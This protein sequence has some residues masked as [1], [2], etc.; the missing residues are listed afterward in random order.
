MFRNQ[1]SRNGPQRSGRRADQ[2]PSRRQPRPSN[3]P[4]RKRHTQPQNRSL[5]DQVQALTSAVRRLVVTREPAPAPQ[6]KPRP[7]NRPANPAKRTQAPKPSQPRAGVLKSKPGKRERTA[8]RLQADRVFPIVD[9]SKRTVGYAVALE[10]K[11]MKPLHVKG[12]IDHPTLASLKFTKST[13]FDMEYAPLPTSMRSDAFAYTSKHPDGFYSWVHG[14]VQ[15]TN[16]RFSIPTGAGGPGDSGRPIL[17]NTGKVVA[18]VLGGANEGSRT[19]LSVVT[20]NQS[21]TA[22]RTVPDD[23]VEWSAVVTAMC[24][25]GNI[26]FPCTAPPF[27]FTDS[28]DTTLDV[29]EAHVDHPNYFDM[30]YHMLGCQVSARRAKRQTSLTQNEYRLAAPYAGRCPACATGSECFSPVKIERVWG[31]PETSSLRIQF[32]AIAGINAKGTPDPALVTYAS[33]SDHRPISANLSEITVSTGSKCVVT[34][35]YGYFILANCP[36]GDI[37]TVSLKEHM[38]TIE[39][40]H[41]KPDVGYEEFAATPIHGTSMRCM[42]FNTSRLTSATH[43]T[44]HRTKPQSETSLISAVNSTVTITVPTNSTVDYECNCAGAFLSGFLRTT[45]KIQGCT[46]ANQCIAALTAR[47]RWTPN[48]D[49]FIRHTDHSPRGKTHVPYPIEQSLCTVPLAR[50][51]AARYSHDSV[52]LTLVTNR[53]VLLTSR[54]LGLE[55]NATAEWINSSTRRTFKLPSEGLEYTWGNNEPIRLWPQGS[56]SGDAHGYPHEAIAYHYSRAPVHTIA[57]LSVLAFVIIASAIFCACK[58]RSL[59]SALRSPY[60]LAPNATVP[61]CLTLL[62]CVRQAKAATYFEAS[63]YLWDNY[64]PMF[65]AQLAIPMASIFLLLKCCSLT[66]TFLAVAGALL[67][68]ISA[69]EHV[70]NVPNSPLLSYKALVDRPGFSPLPLELKVVSSSIQPTLTRHYVTCRYHTVVPSPKVKCCGTLQCG[71]ST[72]PDYR[73]QAFAGVYPF[74]WGG[75]QCFCESENTQLSEVYL[76]A[77]S[78][79]PED[80]ASA[81]SI[82]NPTTQVT[83]RLTVGTST[84]ETTVYANGVSPGFAGPAKVLA[85]PLSTSWSP[86]DSKVVI[87]NRQVFNYDFPEYGAG[88][89]GTFGDIQLPALDSKDFYANTG[90]VLNRP[91]ASS[92]HVPYTQTPSGFEYWRANRGMDL[93]KTAPYGC[94]I[95]PSPLRAVNCSYGFIPVSVDIPDSAFTR[96]EDVPA[97]SGLKC[98]IIDC[99]HSAGFGGLLRLDFSAD[100]AGSCGLHSHDAS[101]LLKDSLIP[102]NSSGSYVG[103]FSTASPQAEFEVTLCSARAPCKAPCRP[104][105]EHVAPHPHLAS[106]TFQSSISPTGWAWLFSLL[107]GGISLTTLGLLAALILSIVNCTRR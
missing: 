40:V 106:Q 39:Y 41:S 97:V 32:S 1:N 80:Y 64:P 17:D 84:S 95:T 51:P 102:V 30:M 2:A 11:I 86:F 68:A 101:A 48:T 18:I 38:C 70:A 49:D 78:S 100:R 31:S 9:E 107:G 85:G 35:A 43:L 59:R 29:L 63:T 71:T 23:T 25:L 104:P 22:T 103:R 6:R 36:P 62:C 28:P 50:L 54:Q 42:A 69:H 66:F 34:A 82:L 73:C 57:I 67:P 46:V 88:T 27:C 33:P 94:L 7:T 52:E 19:A 87:Y 90:I 96:I 61:L 5:V 92:L 45:T 81:Y 105:I 12:T 56:A 8:L 15:C 79:C 93:N 75:A 74:M 37:L 20:W 26:T 76:Q 58:W 14:A 83:L 53:R 4:G 60:A 72:L 89:P 55:P 99:V 24:F 44:L 47:T 21:G 10:G 3:Q 77:D 98:Q 13:S 16:G 91:D 65:W